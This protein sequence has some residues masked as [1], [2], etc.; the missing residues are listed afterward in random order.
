[1][2]KHAPAPALLTD[3]MMI[4][5]MGETPPRPSLSLSLRA[6]TALVTKL[7]LSLVT[8][9]ILGAVYANAINSW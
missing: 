4:F 2:P 1:M 7:A 8:P 3:L 6:L 5:M 9:S